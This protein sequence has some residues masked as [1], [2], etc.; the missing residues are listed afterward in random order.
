M[1]KDIPPAA[2][3]RHT[4]EGQLAA[5]SHRIYKSG[6]SINILLTRSEAIKVAENLLRKAALLKE[7]GLTEEWAVQLWTVG[8]KT[9]QFGIVTQKRSV[10]KKRKSKSTV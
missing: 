5:P 2:K 8:S 7:E 3:S 9:L 10:R 6:K 4:A 1:K